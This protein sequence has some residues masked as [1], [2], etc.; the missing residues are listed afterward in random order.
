VSHAARTPSFAA[1]SSDSSIV[2][3][4]A[5]VGPVENLCAVTPGEGAAANGLGTIDEVKTAYD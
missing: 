1:A 4:F 2:F 5:S 3:D